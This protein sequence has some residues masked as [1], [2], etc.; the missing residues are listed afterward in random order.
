[1]LSGFVLVSWS[2]KTTQIY[3][4]LHLWQRNCNT[5]YFFFNTTVAP[6]EK[7][8][9][10]KLT[11]KMTASLTLQIMNVRLTWNLRLGET[12]FQTK[13]YCICFFFFKNLSL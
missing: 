2:E 8:S 3:T 6:T 12:L 13:A 10:D 1:M 7:Y 5:F 9:M 4:I 11:V